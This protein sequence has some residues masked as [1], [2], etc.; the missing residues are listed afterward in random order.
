[1]TTTHIPET[2]NHFTVLCFGGYYGDL[3]TRVIG[4][5]IANAFCEEMIGIWDTVRDDDADILLCAMLT[6]MRHTGFTTD[7]GSWLSG[8]YNVY[9][10]R[11]MFNV[12]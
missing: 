6:Y 7:Q 9:G 1:M 5:K 3:P 12:H 8:S 4:A 11:L 2:D 10:D